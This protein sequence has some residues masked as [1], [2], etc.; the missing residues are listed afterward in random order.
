V[1]EDKK[2]FVIEVPEE[3]REMGEA[4]QELLSQ[5]TAANRVARADGRAVDYGALE[6]MVSQQGRKIERGA[7]RVMLQALDVDKAQV[8]ID[9]KAHARV[10]RFPSAYYT[11]S[12]E[13]AVT[14]SLYREVG[15]RNGKTVDAVSLRVGV[16]GDGWL[17]NTAKIMA[18]LVAQTTSRDAARTAKE[19]GRVEYSRSAFED[20][21]HVMG[22]Q[23]VPQSRDIEEQL[24]NA[25]GVPKEACAV[26]ASLDRVSL[27]MEEPRERPVGRPKKGAPKRP[28]ARNYRMAW[29]GTVTLHDGEGK[30]L[31]TIRYGL[32]PHGDPVDLV[33]SLVGDVAKL[34]EKRPDLRVA[35]LA[36]G[37]HDLWSL[38]ERWLNEEA[39]GA[40]VH[41]LVDLW[42]LLEK[43]GKA[44]RVIHGE[45]GAEGVLRRWRLALL[46][47]SSAAGQ[48]ILELWGSGRRN[49]RVDG[50]R[51]VRE[52]IT[53][54]MNH[55]HRMNYASARRNGLPVGS[56]NV[57]ATC[58]SLVEMRMK[59]PGARWKEETGDHVL[60]LRALTLSDRW[61]EAMALTLDPLRKAVRAVR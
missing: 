20:V 51:P 26:S 37:A 30:G 11:E 45:S 6:R 10:G 29:C 5:V 33:M 25:Y 55:R 16:V 8:V 40:K 46:N 9:G 52:A 18:F 2:K 32:M 44:A 28:V 54:L 59:R 42:H 34:V 56:G 57:E 41:Y 24:I 36:D 53:Y 7:H 4:I 43:L 1:S 58:K 12:G 17:P 3:L 35:A 21:M 61:D 49:V 38:L 19:L 31:H 50:T 48:L 22:R 14:R 47:H 39:L 60:Q 13:V 15:V 27:P 23:Y